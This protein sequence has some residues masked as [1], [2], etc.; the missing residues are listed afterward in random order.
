MLEGTSAVEFGVNAKGESRKSR[1]KPREKYSK[2]SNGWRRTRV[3]LHCAT[4]RRSVLYEAKNLRN[5][6]IM[7]LLYPRANSSLTARNVTSFKMESQL[8]V[9]DFFP[10]V[11]PRWVPRLFVDYSGISP[12]TSVEVTHAD[13]YNSNNVGLE[14]E[15]G[16]DLQ[17]Q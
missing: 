14:T 3:N 10:S 12:D 2:W 9:W 13:D 11:I 16:F 8:P 5:Q 6:T 1:E 17:G 15:S 4:K 7:S